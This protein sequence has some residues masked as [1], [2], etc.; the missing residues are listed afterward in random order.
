MHKNVI[1]KILYQLSYLKYVQINTKTSSVNKDETNILR[2]LEY[3]HQHYGE[4][5]EEICNCTPMNYLN[6]YRS[7]KQLSFFVRGRY[8]NEAAYIR[9]FYDLSHMER[10][11]KVFGMQPEQ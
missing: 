9:D 2:S 7:K 10:T 6:A 8:Q 4:K 1:W 11:L 3:I 5:I